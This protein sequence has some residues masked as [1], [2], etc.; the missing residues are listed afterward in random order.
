MG[1]LLFVSADDFVILCFFT[2]ILSRMNGVQNL[3]EFI[4]AGKGLLSLNS[5]LFHNP[6]KPVRDALTTSVYSENIG[7]QAPS[8]C[9]PRR[10]EVS[11]LKEKEGES[12]GI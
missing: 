1:D 4:E 12:S 5:T 6:Y 7:F 11:H 3:P 9:C 10:F 2:P 8:F